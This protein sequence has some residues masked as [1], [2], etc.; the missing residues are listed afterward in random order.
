MTSNLGKINATRDLYNSLVVMTRRYELYLTTL[1]TEGERN[2]TLDDLTT[3]VEYLEEILLP[4]LE[5][6]HS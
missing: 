4:S 1:K 2:Q 3:F 6:T 5:E